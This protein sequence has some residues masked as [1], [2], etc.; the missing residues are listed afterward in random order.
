M[1]TNKGDNSRRTLAISMA[2]R[3]QPLNRGLIC[4]SFLQLIWDMDYWPLYRGWPLNS[5]SLMEFQLH[6]CIN[7]INLKILYNCFV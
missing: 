5:D 1:A 7:D 3:W 4:N 6:T 2:K